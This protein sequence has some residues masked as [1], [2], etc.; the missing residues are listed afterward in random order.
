MKG[1]SIFHIGK[2]MLASGYLL[3]LFFGTG[4]V[5]VVRLRCGFMEFPVSTVVVATYYDN[6]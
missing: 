4:W 1:L 5:L 6:N 3:T 2:K